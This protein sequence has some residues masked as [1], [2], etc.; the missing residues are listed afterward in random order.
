[1]DQPRKRRAGA[2]SGLEIHFLGK[3]GLVVNFKIPPV[4]HVVRQPLLGATDVLRLRWRRGVG[5]DAPNSSQGLLGSEEPCFQFMFGEDNGHRFG[6]GPFCSL[7]QGWTK[8]CRAIVVSVKHDKN[9]FR[10]RARL[11]RH[12]KGALEFAFPDNPVSF[13]TERTCD[14]HIRNIKALVEDS[15]QQDWYAFHLGLAFHDWGN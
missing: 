3:G 14:L 1:M 9:R 4:P 5:R 7:L 13:D 10:P 2:S 15:A 8:T 6:A 11:Q 12:L